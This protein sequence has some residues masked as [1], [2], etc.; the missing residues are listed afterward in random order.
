M[1]MPGM[2]TPEQVAEAAAASGAAF[3]ELLR[4][5]VRAH[6]EQG[7]RLAISEETAGVEPRT[8]A[9]AGQMLDDRD[10]YLPRLSETEK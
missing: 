8:K 10:A 4:K 6:M 5:H 9:L 3:D 2:V 7:V 1:P